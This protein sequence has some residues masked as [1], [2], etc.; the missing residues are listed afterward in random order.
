[1]PRPS[2]KPSGRDAV[3]PGGVASKL[4]W[5]VGGHPRDNSGS[6]WREITYQSEFGTTYIGQ[7]LKEDAALIVQAVNSHAA[8]VQAL[9][10]LLPYLEVEL[11]SDA[12]NT[13]DEESKQILRSDIE[14]AQAAIKLAGQED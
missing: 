7:A 1:M 12:M 3:K 6:D 10:A 13:E 2:P 11:E 9:K 14:A 8:L 5:S 4:P